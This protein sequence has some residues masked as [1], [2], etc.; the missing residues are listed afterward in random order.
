MMNKE[1]QDILEGLSE[2][3]RKE[4]LQWL[5]SDSFNNTKHEIQ[6]MPTDFG[7]PMIIMP[8]G[9]A[10]QL[11][12]YFAGQALVNLNS[13]RLMTD[14]LQGI[15]RN[16]G[17]PI[18]ECMAWICYD[19]ADQMLRERDRQGDEKLGAHRQKREADMLAERGRPN[20]D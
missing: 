9:T 8:M 14:C 15:A 16:Y 17:I 20:D 6:Q 7:G 11:R 1:L 3:G 18:S 13:D 10:H 5:W 19:V 4:A 12:D 2:E